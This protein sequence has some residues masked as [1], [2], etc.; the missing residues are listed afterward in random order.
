MEGDDSG[1]P[2]N[3]RT[4][5]VHRAGWW[6]VEGSKVPWRKPRPVSPCLLMD[7]GLSEEFD[8]APRPDESCRAMIPSPLEECLVAMAGSRFTMSIRAPAEEE[9]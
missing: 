3:G 2:E 8:P 9:A 1:G 5:P 4:D 6:S 7:D